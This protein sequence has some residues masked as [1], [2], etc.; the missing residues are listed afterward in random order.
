MFSSSLFLQ[1][2]VTPIALELVDQA[3]N[4]SESKANQ[5]EVWEALLATAKP[6]LPTENPDLTD[7]TLSSEQE[8]N[9]EC[10]GGGGGLAGGSDSIVHHLGGPTRGSLVPCT[11]N[12]EDIAMDDDT[13]T[14]DARTSH[15]ETSEVEDQSGSRSAASKTAS[16]AKKKK[17]GAFSRSAYTKRR[18]QRRLPMSQLAIET[19]SQSISSGSAGASKRRMSSD[20]EKS[21][22]IKKSKESVQEEDDVVEAGEPVSLFV[23][24]EITV[25]GDSSNKEVTS[26]DESNEIDLGKGKRKRYKNVRMMPIDDVVTA[27]SPARIKTS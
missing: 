19:P 14:S 13:A 15:D 16:S 1:A 21:S 5:Q 25:G 12:Y 23:R 24:D 17:A 26:A 6:A 10:G 3:V 9:N 11:F 20:N 18:R 2:V 27:K 22:Q 4:A 8:D 7:N